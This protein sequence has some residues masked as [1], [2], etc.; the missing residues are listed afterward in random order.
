M[1]PAA[2][3]VCLSSKRLLLNKVRT[4]PLYVMQ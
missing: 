4:K 3:E 1:E 2:F